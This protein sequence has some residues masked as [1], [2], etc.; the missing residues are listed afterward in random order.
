MDTR[1]INYRRAVEAFE[2][3]DYRSAIPVLQGLLADR[4]EAV[5]VRMLLARSYYHSASLEPAAE[6]LRVVLDQQPTEAYAHLLLARTLE[7]QSRAEEAR[8]HR[9]LAAVLT[10]DD[11]LAATHEVGR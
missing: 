6:Q 3:K 10:G 4:P 11:T 9:K 7:R 1:W 8:P 2:A 5:E